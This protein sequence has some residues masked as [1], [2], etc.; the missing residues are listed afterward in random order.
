MI[1]LKKN[2]ADKIENSHFHCL[3]ENTEKHKVFSVSANKNVNNV[4]KKNPC[5]N[6]NYYQIQDEIYW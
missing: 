1:F 2:L 6:W 3:G 5:K 4:N